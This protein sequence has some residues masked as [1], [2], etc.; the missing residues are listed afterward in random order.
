M[1]W[2]Q[3]ENLKKLA[4]NIFYKC[5]YSPQF[6]PP[7]LTFVVLS[8]IMLPLHVPFWLLRQPL[9]FNDYAEV[10]AFTHANSN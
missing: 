7:P 1:K 6:F 10:A 4:Y 3:N 5:I 2:K 8:L 9:H